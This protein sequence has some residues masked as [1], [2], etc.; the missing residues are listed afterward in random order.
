MNYP[1]ADNCA[2]R[3]IDRSARIKYGTQLSSSMQN[4]ELKKRKRQRNKIIKQFENE[5][6]FSWYVQIFIV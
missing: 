3:T 6:D 5:L 2:E 1:C 4:S